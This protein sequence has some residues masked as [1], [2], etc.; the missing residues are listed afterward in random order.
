ME[1][2]LQITFFALVLL[3]LALIL[4]ARMASQYAIVE[5]YQRDYLQLEAQG[6]PNEVT[7]AAVLAT[8]PEI[9]RCCSP[10]CSA[11]TAAPRAIWAW[12]TPP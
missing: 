6:E 5:D 9:H 8:P 12:K 1:R 10:A 4:A 2:K 11:W 3:A 7:K